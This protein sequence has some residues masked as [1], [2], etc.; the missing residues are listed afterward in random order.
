MEAIIALVLTFLAGLFCFLKTGKKMLSWSVASVIMPAFV[1]FAEFIL[2]Y[3]GGGA[4]MWPI[5]LF[6]ASFAGFIS[7]ALGVG[8]GFYIQKRAKNT[9]A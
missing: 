3:K 7:A 6:V 5:A 1:L 9:K 8:I 2:P 4:S